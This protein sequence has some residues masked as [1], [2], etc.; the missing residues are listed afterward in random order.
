MK[1]LDY[2]GDFAI[3]GIIQVRFR[4]DIHSD[5]TVGFIAPWWG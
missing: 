5:R 2:F 3:Y 1:F 4:V